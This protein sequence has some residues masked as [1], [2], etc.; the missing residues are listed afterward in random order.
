M[1]IRAFEDRLHLRDFCAF[2]GELGYGPDTRRARFGLLRLR[3]P[4]KYVAA[5][6]RGGRVEKS[7]RARHCAQPGLQIVRHDQRINL[8][9]GIP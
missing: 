5:I 2:R 6:R 9:I 7:F 1:E 3:D 8:R 4:A